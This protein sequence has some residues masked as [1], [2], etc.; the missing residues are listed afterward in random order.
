MSPDPKRIQSVFAVVL[1]AEGDPAARAALLDRECGD[2]EELRLRVMALL[3]AHDDPASIFRQPAAT[4]FVGG[5]PPTEEFLQEEDE[6]DKLTFLQPSDKPGVRGRLG[7]YDVLEVL[8]R[9]GFGIVLRALDEKLQRVVAIKVLAPEIAATSPARKRFLREARAAAAVRQENIVQIHAVEE[10]PIPYLVMEY[11]P[12][13]NLQQKL[14]AT[15]PLETMEMVRLAAQIA[16]GVAAAHAKGLI[17]RDIKPGNIL[18]EAGTETRVKITDFG[19]AR[20]ADDASLTQSGIVAG[21]PMYMAPEQAKG[22]KIDQRADLFSMGSVFYVMLSGRP[23]FRAPSTLA[24]LR[25]VAEDHPRPITEIIPE[26]PSWLCDLINKLH[27]KDPNDRFQ[28]AQEVADLLEE[29]LTEMKTHGTLAHPPRFP[30]KKPPV[31]K[32]VCWIIA[33]MVLLA[34]M[35]IFTLSNFGGRHDAAPTTPTTYPAAKTT[36]PQPPHDT[37]PKLIADPGPQ[38]IDSRAYLPLSESATRKVID[39]KE[40]HGVSPEAVVKWAEAL[41]SGYVP[42][43]IGDHAAA[44]TRQVHAIA[45]KLSGRPLET[46][47]WFGSLEE[48]M[49]AATEYQADRYRALQAQ[50]YDIPGKGMHILRVWLRDHGLFPTYYVFPHSNLETQLASVRKGGGKPSL[51]VPCHR[52]NPALTLMHWVTDGGHSGWR[53]GVN[54]TCE[55]L[56]PFADA[57]KAKNLFVSIAVAYRDEKGQTRFGAVAWENPAR[58]DCA[59]KADMT[60]AEYEAELTKRKQEGLRPVTVTSYDDNGTTRYAASWVR[61]VMR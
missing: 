4:P 13:R 7:H 35:L 44:N 9:G 25:R 47:L 8:G 58:L 11:V 51:L 28:T 41:E 27:A 32:A 55:Q 34:L 29:C 54:L 33:A 36:Q 14:D 53:T 60:T 37:T 20:A 10:Q 52:P 59:F 56:A 12:G 5:T 45:V 57:S 39:F 2:D 16:R 21:T 48:D 31:R 42:I 43:V 15:G 19:L 17:H 40:I 38:F 6:Q 22:E 49:T 50:Y 24:V 23:P 3:V 30:E 46:R 61:F 18:L 1:E 26:A